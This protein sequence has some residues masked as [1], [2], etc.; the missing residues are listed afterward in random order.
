M[1]RYILPLLQL[2]FRGK[3]TFLGCIQ[4]P[5]IMQ[6][7]HA[8]PKKPP[9]DI[10][11]NR[12]TSAHSKV[13]LSA[14][15]KYV[16]VENG[17][18]SKLLSSLLLSSQSHTSPSPTVKFVSVR[19]LGIRVIFMICGAVSPP[20]DIKDRSTALVHI[21]TNLTIQASHFDLVLKIYCNGLI[22]QN[23]SPQMHPWSN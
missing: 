11:N 6:T 14:P 4:A 7:L 10:V 8:I 17:S 12:S 16:S 19:L 1:E 18:D 3:T 21:Q 23:M 20:V 2:I 13:S 5:S 22:D 15:Q 9:G